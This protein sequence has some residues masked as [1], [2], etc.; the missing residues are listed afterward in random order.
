[1]VQTV[2]QIIQSLLQLV[3]LENA[4][5]DGFGV[6]VLRNVSK[7]SSHIH[8][9]K[10]TKLCNTFIVTYFNNIFNSMQFTKILTY[11]CSSLSS[12]KSLLQLP[13]TQ[14]I[15]KQVPKLFFKNNNC[16]MFKG[17]GSIL[18]LFF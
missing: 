2:E 1:M 4:E 18:P 17:N 9:I 15:F 8:M 11:Q 5:K 16:T 14:R 12:S 7:N 3:V 6:N 13:T 10:E